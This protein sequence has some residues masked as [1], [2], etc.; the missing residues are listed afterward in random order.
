MR[1]SA[2]AQYA[3]IAMLELAGNY[4]DPQLMQVKT[5]ADLHGISARVALYDGTLRIDPIAEDGFALNAHL[6]FA[7]PVR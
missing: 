7:V 1:M 6:P 3:C 5:I 2:K 4:Q